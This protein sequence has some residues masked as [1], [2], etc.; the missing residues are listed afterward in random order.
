LAIFFSPTWLPD[1]ISNCDR[2][3]YPPFLLS[4]SLCGNRKIYYGRFYSALLVMVPFCGLFDVCSTL[5]QP[6][7][8]DFKIEGVWNGSQTR[9]FFPPPPP[10][11]S[12][13]CCFPL[14]K[15]PPLPPNF[16]LVEPVA[17]LDFY[18]PHG[19]R[20]SPPPKTDSPCLGFPLFLLLFSC[21][22][23]AGACFFEL[24]LSQT[25]LRFLPPPFFFF[26][27]FRLL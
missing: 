26:S 8:R 19:G 3:P 20:G 15:S 9:F 4:Y 14:G 25:F 11:F 6:L 27:H 7:P 24:P 13:R 10:S 2:P 17:P 1:G 18:F 16:F 21:T 23:Y 22:L 12:A 5:S